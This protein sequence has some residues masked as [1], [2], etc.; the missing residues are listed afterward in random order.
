MGLFGEE[1]AASPAVAMPTGFNVTGA[2]AAGTGSLRAAWRARRTRHAAP[3][4][5]PLRERARGRVARR[6]PGLAL[7]VLK[8]PLAGVRT[9]HPTARSAPGLPDQKQANAAY[10]NDVGS[11]RTAL[12]RRLWAAAERQAGTEPVPT[13]R[14]HRRHQAWALADP[15][16]IPAPAPPPS[17]RPAGRQRGHWRGLL[18]RLPRVPHLHAAVPAEAGEPPQMDDAGVAQGGRPA[19]P[20]APQHMRAAPE[21]AAPRWPR[22]PSPTLTPPLPRST[23]ATCPSGRRRCRRHSRRAHLAGLRP[24]SRPATC[25]CCTARAWTRW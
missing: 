20:A 3:R 21:A 4:A 9:P 17:P 12:V 1:P 15:S 24:C 25:G 7:V 22:P 14:S 19:L 11:L 10:S 16:P 23:R 8:L 5:A 2:R 6:C 18:C 13:R